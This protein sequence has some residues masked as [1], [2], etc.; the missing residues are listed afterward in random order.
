LGVDVWTWAETDAEEGDAGADA[1]DL[2][3][4]VGVEAKPVAPT[5]TPGASPS[6]ATL[7]A[8][9]D[10]AATAATKTAIE[11]IAQRSNLTARRPA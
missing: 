4:P 7:P 9:S 5:G 11:R 3:L 2:A 8:K 10:I 1:P 6:A